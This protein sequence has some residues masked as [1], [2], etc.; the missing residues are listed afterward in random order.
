MR[1]LFIGILLRTSEASPKTN[2]I[3]FCSPLR[4]SPSPP[5]TPC[6]LQD[7]RDMLQEGE[8]AAAGAAEKE[9]A[10]EAAKEATP[11]V[12]E[13]GNEEAEA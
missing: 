7:F 3:T 11:E 8:K 13:G 2:N 5:P 6:S 10:A 4:S 1:R 12:G 9:K